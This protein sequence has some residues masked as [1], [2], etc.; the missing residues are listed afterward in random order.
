MHPRPHCVKTLAQSFWSRVQQSDGC[1]LWT[2][3]KNHKGYGTIRARCTQGKH[4]AA[5]RV[6]WELH[7]GPIPAGMLVCH[8]CDNPGCVRPDHLFLGTP[9]DNSADMAHKGRSTIGDRN[10]AHIHKERMKRGEAHYM[11]HLTTE[12]VLAIRARYAAGEKPNMLAL[13]YGV[14]PHSIRAIIHRRNWAHIDAP[15]WH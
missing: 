2:G 8:H 15:V 3:A 14:K 10:P 4:R 13:E 7:Y 9:A 5:H 11:T 1:W 12:D 6:S